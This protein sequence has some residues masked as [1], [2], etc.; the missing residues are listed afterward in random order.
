MHTSMHNWRAA[1]MQ[2]TNVGATPTPAVST[3]QRTTGTGTE[4]GTGTGTGTGGAS[5]RMS[6]E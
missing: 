4:T 5:R 1:K 6:L 3:P 2:E